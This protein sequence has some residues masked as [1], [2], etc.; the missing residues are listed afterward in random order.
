MTDKQCSGAQMCKMVMCPA[1]SPHECDG[2]GSI[3]GCQMR[4]VRCLPVP[5]PQM[6][7]C[8]DAR[9]LDDCWSCQ[10]SNA[11]P[12]NDDC[13]RVH[14]ACPACIPVEQVKPEPQLADLLPPDEPTVRE[15][16][17]NTA[18]GART[19]GYV[20]NLPG[21]QSGKYVPL[22][23]YERVDNVRARLYDRWFEAC[24]ERD[25]AVHAKQITDLK[26]AATLTKLFKANRIV[27]E[28][29]GKLA[30][31]Q[32]DKECI[33]SEFVQSV[34]DSN[35]E[36]KRIAQERNEAHQEIERLRENGM[37]VSDE[38]EQIR[39]ERNEARSD[40]ALCQ[41][42]I[43]QLERRL[44]AARAVG[45]EMEKQRN[46]AR[47]E[48]ASA[49]EDVEH[50]RRACDGLTEGVSYWRKKSAAATAERDEERKESEWWRS[51]DR[52]V[53]IQRELEAERDEARRE[54][55]KACED[56]SEFFFTHTPRRGLETH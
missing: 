13:G 47:R 17:C 36:V 9:M 4:D 41:R 23:D 15:F 5:R 55:A 50:L 51:S 1:H 33:L 7:I 45:S 11:H 20:V 42:E 53:L 27:R 35:A 8:P 37:M 48:L 56:V 40:L 34:K 28:K 44:F 21:D 29:R 52:S 6:M 32:A 49:C 12:Y 2:H 14:S 39:V 31:A 19:G 38:L 30:D 3:S 10:A 26:Q 16:R 18:P 24:R 22:A 54:L 46:E 43:Q 25:E